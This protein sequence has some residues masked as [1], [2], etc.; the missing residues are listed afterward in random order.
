MTLD[1]RGGN[2]VISLRVPLPF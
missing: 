2:R 1:E